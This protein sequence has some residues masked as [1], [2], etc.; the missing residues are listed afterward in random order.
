MTI[1]TQDDVVALRGIRRVLRRYRRNY[2]STSNHC[3]ED[4]SVPRY[5]HGARRSNEERQS[6]AT[7][8]W[9]RCRHRTH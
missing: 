3:A 6:G 5:S 2:R 1:E 7:D 4:S 9:N 8:Q